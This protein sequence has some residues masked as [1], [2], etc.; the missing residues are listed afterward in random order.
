MRLAV[1]GL[2]QGRHLAHWAGQAGM[3][4]VALC[5]HDKHLLESAGSDH[6]GARLTSRWQ[7]LLSYDLDAVALVND[8][9][10]HAAMA[11]AFLDAGI[12]VLSESAA[13]TSEAEGRSL[14]EAADRAH[15]TYSF[16]ENYVAHPHVRVIADALAAD[17][18]G[19]VQLIEADYLH[20]MA[21]ST[22]DSLIRNS[23][24]W[25][26]RISPAAYCTHTLSPILHLTGAWPLEVSAFPVDDTDPRPAVVMA[27][28]LSTGALAITRHG[29]L[30]GESESHW[31]WLSVR[32]S[33]GLIESSRAPGE[34]AWDVRLRKEG[35]SVDQSEAVEETRRATRVELNGQP[36]GRHHEGTVLMLQAFRNTVESGAAPMVPV[37]AAVAASLVGVAGAESLARRSS[38]VAVPDV[39]EQ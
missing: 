11:I 10:A 30:Q 34:A 26:G 23:T 31:S 22:V 6:P 16:A 14:I 3:D 39:R 21:P 24:T 5:D 36:V 4:V 27:V 25:R 38:L 13:C 20:A 8:F 32:G 7:D 37:R 35:W 18:V 19:S 9:D 28:R 29:F 33:T 12:H 1:I 2:G 17:E 15:V